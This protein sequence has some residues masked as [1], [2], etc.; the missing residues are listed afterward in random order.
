MTVTRPVIHYLAGHRELPPCSVGKWEAI[1]PAFWEVTCPDCLV[2]LPFAIAQFR[3]AYTQLA[4][5]VLH[6]LWP[7]HRGAKG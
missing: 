2:S 4:W 6:S 1:S 5:S 3:V 7:R